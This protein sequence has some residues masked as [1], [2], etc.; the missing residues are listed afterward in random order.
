MTAA[1][2]TQAT[3]DR[4]AGPDAARRPDA[5]FWDRIAARYARRPIADEAA[6]AEKLS[7]IREALPPGARV[8]ELGCGTGGT[9]LALAPHAARI[10]ATDLSAEMIAIARERAAGAG[11]DPERVVFS[12]A[13]L[14]EVAPA[15]PP[16][17]VLA[18]NLLH[19]VEDR[20]GALA[21]IRAML[22]AGGVFA[23][24]TACL[25]DF[26]P[27]F[28]WVAPLGRALGRLP[29]VEVFTEAA[30]LEELSAAGFA[31]ERRFR[32]SRSAALFTLA[33]AV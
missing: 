7:L 24:S 9:A 25:G 33:R 21:R 6:Y 1:P 2:A 20:A 22:P 30:F 26:M 29:H 27:W 23:A 31:V 16:D 13:P 8:L 18:M 11:A 10:E 32:P 19:L 17:A 4:D 12:V 5:R 3:P 15:T 14:G 28:R